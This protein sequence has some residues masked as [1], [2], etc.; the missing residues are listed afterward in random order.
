[1]SLSDIR[2]Y[3]GYKRRYIKYLQQS[4]KL[5]KMTLREKEEY[6]NNLY[7]PIFGTN[8]N[9]ENPTRFYE[10]IQVSKLYGRDNE[11][12]AKLSDKYEV[13]DYIKSKIG[14]KYLVP[15]IGVYDSFNEINFDKLPSKFV[16]KCNH[17]SGSVTIV[18]DKYKVNWKKLKYKYDFCLKVDYSKAMM[19]NHYSL[20]KPK[21]IIEK[22]LT[23]S[24]DEI[25]N[26]YK[27]LCI[28]GEPYYCW[29]IEDRFLNRNRIIYDMNWNI[30]DWDCN[31][32]SEKAIPKPKNFD[33][34]KNLAK[35]LS[36]DFQQVRVDFYN[37]DGKI[38]FGELTFTPMSGLEFIN[39]DIDIRCGKLWDEALSNKL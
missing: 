29:A 18:R 6:L 39:P 10:K 28:K 26:D 38:Y 16:I 35:R 7:R 22:L 17:D 36:E 34:M 2:S 21:I 24:N 14:E 33:V 13:R 15:L 23:K 32:I 37:I 12:K 20:I 4:K 1:M 31:G 30:V 3:L 25:A 27:F 5:D 11:I 9:F 19:E 8:I